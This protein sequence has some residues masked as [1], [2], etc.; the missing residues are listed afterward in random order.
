MTTAVEH[1]DAAPVRHGPPP[2]PRGWRRLLYPGFLRAAWMAPL[3]FGIGSTIVVLCRWWGGWDP[4]WFGE[5]IVLVGGMVTA[6]IGFL[7]GLGAF[8]YWLYWVS[9]RPTRPETHDSHGAY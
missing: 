4:I 5:I 7:L 9:G 6:P 3:F 1:H 8:D 2:P